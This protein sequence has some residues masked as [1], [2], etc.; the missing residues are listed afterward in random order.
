METGYEETPYVKGSKRKTKKKG[1][2]KGVCP[3]TKQKH[4]TLWF[5]RWDEPRSGKLFVWSSEVR[6]INYLYEFCIACG[7]AKRPVPVYAT[8]GKEVKKS[9]ESKSGYEYK[10]IITQDLNSEKLGTI[11]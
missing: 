8:S 6:K 10:N 7:G 9:M 4:D 3:V 5:K 1:T 11:K 2:G